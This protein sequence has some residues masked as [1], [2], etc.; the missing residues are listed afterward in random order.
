M[1]ATL[2][3]ANDLFIVLS[4]NPRRVKRLARKGEI[5]HVLLPGDEV[6]FKAEEI[7]DWIED[8]PHL[9]AGEIDPADIL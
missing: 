4:L 8:L 3:D 7:A 2:L 6:R 5:P 1:I 9:P